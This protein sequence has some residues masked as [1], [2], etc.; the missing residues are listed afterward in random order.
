MTDFFRV[1]RRL[2][3]ALCLLAAGCG[4]TQND[5]LETTE[6]SIQP[7]TL[8]LQL[9]PAAIRVGES[10]ELS[11]SA[12]LATGCV[13][14]GDWQGV[15]P[16]AGSETVSPTGAGT[17]TYGAA[18]PASPSSVAR[19]CRCFRCHRRRHLRRSRVW[20]WRSV[21]RPTGL[22]WSWASRRC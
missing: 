21:F 19:P 12:P 13:A 7:L 20:L 2:G 17:Y 3:V 18:A 22:K 11:W 1:P 6:A 16:A 10:A 5:P 15:R 14:E 4:D 9:T 8:S